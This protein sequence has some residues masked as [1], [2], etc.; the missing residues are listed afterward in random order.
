MRIL[1]LEKI[2]CSSDAVL[3]RLRLANEDYFTVVN[4]IKA[5][6]YL[7]VDNNTLLRFSLSYLFIKLVL[8]DSIGQYRTRASVIR[9]PSWCY[10]QV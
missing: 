9:I 1:R 6:S 8:D 3:A 10:D 4:S 7:I 5:C 2:S